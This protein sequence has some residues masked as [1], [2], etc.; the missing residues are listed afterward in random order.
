MTSATSSASRQARRALRALRYLPSD[1]AL[2]GLR[3]WRARHFPRTGERVLTIS[4]RGLRGA[5]ISLRE[6][7]TD[8]QVLWYTLRERGHL[9]PAGLGE[10]HMI[11]DLGA[12][13]GT[14]MA[15]F[16][17]L[18]PSA[19]IVGVE[20]HPTNAEL[21]RANVTRWQDRC[22]VLEA[23]VSSTP[24]HVFLTDEPGA[25]DAI[26]IDQA[27]QGLSVPTVSLAAIVKRY[28]P[29]DYLKVNIEGAERELIASPG[30]EGIRAVKIEVHPPLTAAECSARLKELGFA[31]RVEQ[32]GNFV[33]V[34]GMK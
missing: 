17:I 2:G 14:T 15:H 29:V 19:R 22:S 4:P 33:F 31:P 34:S 7:A 8:A 12:N 1:V 20:P 18:H 11:V 3:F 5:P 10:L 32:V 9:P 28:G 23:A 30:W 26:R 25:E 16:A 13:I 27:A 6:G 21:C 24:G